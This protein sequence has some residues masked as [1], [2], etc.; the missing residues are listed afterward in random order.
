MPDK[1]FFDTNV[2]VYALAE[3]DSRTAR[4][5]E[6]LDAGGVVSVQVLNE[7]V[8]VA[9]RK[10]SMSWSEIADAVGA[11]VAL[12]PSP[13]EITLATHEAARRIAENYGYS[14]YDALVIAAAIEGE[15]KTL[16]SEDLRNGQTIDGR[17]TIRNP[18]ARSRQ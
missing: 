16:F 1:A 8:S 13:V 6:L 17:I 14:I 12:C 15:C 5:E 10:M 7:F 9:R 11:I 2:V 4:A 18:F 3:G